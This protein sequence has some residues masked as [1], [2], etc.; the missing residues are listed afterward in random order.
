MAPKALL[1]LSLFGAS[2]GG[3][4]V[5]DGEHD[6]RFVGRWLVTA[7]LSGTYWDSV[8]R[9]DVDGKLELVESKSVGHEGATGF[10]TRG[11]AL[12]CEF[13]DRWSSEGSATLLIA[14]RCSDGRERI[15]EIAFN[16]DASRNSV[17]TYR[18]EEGSGARLI[19][20]G[21]EPGWYHGMVW[22]KDQP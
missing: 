12:R 22:I 16:E 2:C 1:I 19:S 8:Y 13:G 21:G 14:G 7:P 18:H 6:A 17:M 5:G 15:I 20:V 10:V 11:S 4:A 3:R 9:F